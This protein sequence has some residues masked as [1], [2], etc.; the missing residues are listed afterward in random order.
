ETGVAGARF[1]YVTAEGS[2][3]VLPEGLLK[4]GA[5]VTVVHAYR[6]SPDGRGAAKLRRALES[7]K[8]DLVSFASASAVRGY[9]DAVG[10][11]L[12]MRAPAAS[13]GPI[14]SEAVTEAG[15]ELRTEAEESTI[16]GLAGAIVRALQ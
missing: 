10:E 6:S 1:L 12:S 16:D 5:A 9:V 3:D 7:G 4:V 11:E 14:T 8:V 15:I 2:R 13:I